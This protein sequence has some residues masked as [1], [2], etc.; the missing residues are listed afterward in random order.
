[1][2]NRLRKNLRKFYKARSIG[3]WIF[4]PRKHMPCTTSL[5]SMGESEDQEAA[6]E[7]TVVPTAELFS[8]GLSIMASISTKKLEKKKKK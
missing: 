2:L 6:A 8:Q 7:V 5:A 1:M 4:R 3:F